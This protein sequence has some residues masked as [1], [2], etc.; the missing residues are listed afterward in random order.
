MLIFCINDHRITALMK[1]VLS[2]AV[3]IGSRNNN[4]E[5]LEVYYPAP[6]MNPPADL[7]EK[8]TALVSYSGGNAAISIDSTTCH[9]LEDMFKQEGLGGQMLIMA[10]MEKAQ[11]PKVMTILI[12]DSLPKNVPEI[13]LKLH[14]I[15]HRFVKPCSLNLDG[16]FSI[17]PNVVW[18][19]IGAVDPEEIQLRQ[20]IARAQGTP[21]T[22]HCVDKFPRMTDYVVPSGVRIADTSRVRLGAYL[23]EGTTVMQAGFVNFNAG[24][25]GACMVEGRISS[26][27]IVGK[28]SD[29]GGGCSTMGTLSGGNDTRI[30]IGENCLIGANAG[31]GI[32]LGDR[33]TIEAGLYL[34]AGSKVSCITEDESLTGVFKAAALAGKSDLLFRRHSQNG[35]IECIQNKASIVLNKELHQKQ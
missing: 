18:T 13:Y 27:V 22:V 8:L 9:A 2:V 29:L 10:A 1:N 14:L 28:G 12:E 25:L 15:S 30:T 3:G 5:W 16:I 33:C 31:V 11:K 23:G 20:M 26:G 6:L 17:L 21:L 35:Q 19:N 4:D 32:P 7:I 34:T 24:T